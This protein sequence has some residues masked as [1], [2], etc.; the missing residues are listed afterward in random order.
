MSDK[1]IYIIDDDPIYQVLINKIIATSG[2][3]YQIVSFKNGREALDSLIQAIVSNNNI[4][5]IILLDLEMPIMDGWDFM[6]N[7][8]NLFTEQSGKSDIDIITSSISY[9]DIERAKTFPEI[10][11]YF[12]KPVDSTKLL[13]I[14]RKNNVN[15]DKSNG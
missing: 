10:L 7:V 8:E 12:P 6:K 2:I 15:K 11:G 5:E 9:E 13:E 3:D 1:I 4:P 14:T